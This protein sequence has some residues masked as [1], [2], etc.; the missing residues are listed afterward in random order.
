MF[1]F[2]FAVFVCLF[3]FAMF[4]FLFA[5][6]LVCL[7][8]RPPTPF[9]FVL[10]FVFVFLIFLSTETIRTV[11]DGEP[12]DVHLDSHTAPDLCVVFTVDL[13]LHTSQYFSVCA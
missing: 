2:V 12:M 10:F 4:L 5:V 1:C 9:L 7:L 6:F 13:H 11:R 3:C 8:F